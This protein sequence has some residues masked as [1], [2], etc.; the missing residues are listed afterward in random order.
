MICLGFVI[1]L[2]CV[3]SEISYKQ[4]F[5]DPFCLLCVNNAGAPLSHGAV[6]VVFGIGFIQVGK[7]RGM[8]SLEHCL[9]DLL[10]LSISSLDFP[11]VN[12]I[13]FS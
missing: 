2:A 12:C 8:Q 13:A 5:A 1:L 4:F 6:V 10:F 3:F 7:R 11:H 9:L